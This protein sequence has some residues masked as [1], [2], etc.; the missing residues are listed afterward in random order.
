MIMAT[1][2][3]TWPTSFPQVAFEPPLACISQQPKNEIYH[4]I[5]VHLGCAIGARP[6]I[7]S[8]NPPSSNLVHNLV[9]NLLAFTEFGPHGTTNPRRKEATQNLQPTMALSDMA[10]II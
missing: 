9:Y 5:D 3:C 4:I 8:H 1:N 6:A 10:S 7:R 2:V